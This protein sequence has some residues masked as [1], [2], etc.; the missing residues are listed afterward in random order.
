MCQHAR[1]V[2]EGFADL[3]HSL[4][5]FVDAGD[6]LPREGYVEGSSAAQECEAETMSGEWG[7]WPT[8]DAW[9]FVGLVSGSGWEH[10]RS[11]AVL[12]NEHERVVRPLSTVA[13][14]AME[15]FA[16]AFYVGEP[17]IEPR[18]RVRRYTN[19]RLQSLHEYGL[20]L[21]TMADGDEAD[22]D[23]LEQTKRQHD[24][25]CALLVASARE[26]NFIV[27]DDRDR[28]RATY[29]QAKV[30]TKTALCKNAVSSSGS[31][32]GSVYYKSL[33]AAAHSTIHGIAQNIQMLDPLGD[34]ENMRIEINAE[35]AATRFIGGVLA[36]MTVLSD[37]YPYCGVPTPEN[38]IN[39]IGFTW[40]GVGKVQV[41]EGVIVPE[42]FRRPGWG[43]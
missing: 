25:E 29:L 36:A 24:A 40:M 34:L 32:L 17:D 28:Y 6:V 35:D 43:K 18:E 37:V 9:F 31:N 20:L 30:P 14:G 4:K 39:E 38:A 27:R 13:R 10:L 12:L 8:R 3:A 21:D 42:A 11:L 1:V 26:F 41:P 23:D 19:I 5:V 22:R 2:S 7:A 15:A 33:S 16:Q